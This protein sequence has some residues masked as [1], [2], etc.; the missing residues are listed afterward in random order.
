MPYL[1]WLDPHVLCD[2]FAENYTIED[3]TSYLQLTYPEKK[4][5]SIRN[6]QRFM[7]DHSIKLQQGLSTQELEQEVRSATTEMGGTAGRKM[8]KSWLQLNGV[9][10]SSERIRLAQAVVA[11]AYHANRRR[12]TDRQVNPQSYRAPYFGY[13]LHVDQNEKLAEFGIVF[14]MA[15]DGRSALIT[16]GAVMPRK[17]NITI[18]DLVY[19][20]SVHEY[21]LWDQLIADHGREFFLAEH[22]Q[23]QLK[24]L[25]VKPDGTIS[26]RPAYRQLTSVQNNRIERLWSEVNKRVGYPL[27][28]AL[29]EMVD[30]HL[31]DKMDGSHLF[32]CSIIGSSVANV[33]LQRFI[34]TWNNHV[35]PKNR[36]PSDYIR[37]RENYRIPP[38][39]LPSTEDAVLMYQNGIYG[40]S[41]TEETQFGENL[42]QG[43][44]FEEQERDQRFWIELEASGGVTM[45][46]NTVINHSYQSFQDAILRFIQITNS[47]L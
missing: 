24:D 27:K 45:L 25:R 1:A 13:N 15:A 14:V 28:Y 32:A 5:I 8:M 4:G 20:A 17:N 30:N 44:P 10:A 47:L 29:H 18:Y 2:L 41:L 21:G 26:G 38:N 16:R 11:P 37:A 12:Q 40:G 46:A 39:A 7:N 23:Y 22:I 35:I 43:R 3:A 19:A 42:L 31:I 6:V 33:L 9:N 34:D 36:K